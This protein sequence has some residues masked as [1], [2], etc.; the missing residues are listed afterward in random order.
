MGW[1]EL[2]RELL[3]DPDDDW[4]K[5]ALCAQTVDADAFF[6]EKGGDS[7]MARKL[8]RQCPV[9]RECLQY[10]LDNGEVYGI[11]GGTSQNQRRRMRN[12]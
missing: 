3:S 5:D 7:A 1:S 2:T 8:C 9:Q 10:A 6:P 12:S 4:R 11:W